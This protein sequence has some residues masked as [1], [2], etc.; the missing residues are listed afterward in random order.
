MR[1]VFFENMPKWGKKG[2]GKE[3]STKWSETIG[4][5][6]RFIYDNIVGEFE[7][8]GYDTKTSKLSLQYLDHEIFQ[9]TPWHLMEHKLQE[10]LGIKTI[11][12]K[13]KIGD[14]VKTNSGDIKILTQLRINVN[15]SYRKNRTDKGYTYR[16][17]RCG[18][19]TE[20]V[21]SH[22]IEGK[23][24]PVCSNQKIVKGI[25]DV[26]T[27]HPNLV[28]YFVNIE[29]AYTYSVGSNTYI[30]VICNDCGHVRNIRLYDLYRYGNSCPKCGDGYSYPNKLMFNLLEQVNI[31]FKPEYSPEWC[32]YE[33]KKKNKKGFYDFYF[34]N[35]NIKY[36]VEMDGGFHTR[37]NNMNGVTKEESKEIDEFKENLAKE[38][39]IKVI[40]IDCKKSELE[41]IKNKII[42]SKLNK[43]LE[44]N[45][46]DWLK[47]H[48]FACS[49]RV[50]EACVLWNTTTEST[51]KIGTI[52]KISGSTVLTYLLQGLELGW[53]NYR[54]KSERKNEKIHKSCELWNNGVKSTQ[55]IGEILNIDRCVIREYLVEGV[56]LS[57]CDYTPK[58]SIRI[59]GLKRSKSVICL[60]NNMT[61]QSV[62]DVSDKSLE[63]FNIKLRSDMVASVCNG[64]YKQYKGFTFEYIDVSA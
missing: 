52:M 32:K 16:C 27:T 15:S 22:L 43:I 3:G 23:G 49:S 34:E 61:F 11:K 31:D 39:G 56:K 19:D 17:L 20:T 62:K 64:K 21:E 36:I 1:D 59:S 29:D 37:D 44:L 38:H 48:E 55:E 26:A 18:T 46:V 8:V 12:Y 14:V 50:K 13:Y 6:I 58:E 30:D 53:C 41:Y 54:T 57:L 33:Y 10:M 47:S 51:V 28:K 5:I 45:S 60:D 63:I 2:S 7:I 40:R 35:N 25:N 42:H 4:M 9:I 24:C